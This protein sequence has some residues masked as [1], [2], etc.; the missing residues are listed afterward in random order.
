MQRAYHRNLSAFFFARRLIYN[1]VLSLVYPIF[2]AL[3]SRELSTMSAVL[4][5]IALS[6]AMTHPLYSVIVR[7]VPR[8]TLAYIARII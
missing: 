2:D 4:Y 5:R 6:I 1:R 7:A 8:I 3:H